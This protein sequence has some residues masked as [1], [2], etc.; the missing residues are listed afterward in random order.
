MQTQTQHAIVEAIILASPEPLPGRKVAEVSD[1]LTPGKVTQVVA[2]LNNRYMESGSS[3][4]IR[5][6]AGGF[7]FYI[8]PEYGGY[9]DELF[10]RRRKMRLTRASLETLAIIAYKQPVTKAEIEH[11]RGV[12]TD[13]VLNNLLEKNMII[14]KGRAKGPGRPLQYGTGDEFLKFFG[15]NKVEDLPHM[16]EIEQLIGN[17]ELEEQPELP[18]AFAAGEEAPVKLNVADGTHVP[19]SDDDDEGDGSR[20]PESEEKNPLND[21]SDLLSEDSDVEVDE[22]ESDTDDASLDSEF[23][24][25]DDD[26]IDKNEEIGDVSGGNGGSDHEV[27]METPAEKTEH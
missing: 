20:Q 23:E 14:L 21:L 18:L 7:Q 27:V 24:D 3:Y 6:L 9:V 8:V 25:A 5:Q 17:R 1:D 16:K 26:D 22:G 19:S 4:R 2:E 15:I 12:A 10:A 11:I 13:G